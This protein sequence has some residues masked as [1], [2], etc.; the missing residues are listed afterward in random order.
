VAYR[1]EGEAAVHRIARLEDELAASR[2]RVMEL[3][4][5]LTAA[6]AEIVR[7]RGT[8][9]SPVA[10]QDRPLSAANVWL[11][12]VGVVLSVLGVV[13]VGVEGYSSERRGIQA[14]LLAL[15]AVGGT[16]A[17]LAS[18]R[19]P[20]WACIAITLGGVVVTFVV[21]VAFFASIWRSL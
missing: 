19:R 17:A 20:T 13:V 10:R 11:T 12:R 7:L 4:G 9:L 5:A 14:A 21:L 1:N 8:P 2:A 16:I 18:R 6:D 3:E 15:P